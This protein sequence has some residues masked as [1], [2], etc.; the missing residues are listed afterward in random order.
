MATRPDLSRHREAWNTRDARRDLKS[1]L[2]AG[3]ELA[4]RVG[5][6]VRF[7]STWI[8]NRLESRA[9]PREKSPL[10]RQEEID[11]DLAPRS[12]KSIEAKR[13]TKRAI[14]SAK[15]GKSIPWR[16][17]KMKFNRDTWYL[18]FYQLSKW[19]SQDVL[20]KFNGI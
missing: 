12:S 2:H 7:L 15:Q 9:K 19:R 10:G 18:E 6:R 16:L 4:S 11:C 13:G 8:I 3:C 14:F 17:I 5:F 1:R 20:R